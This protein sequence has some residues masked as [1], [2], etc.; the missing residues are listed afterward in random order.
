MSAFYRITSVPLT[1]G[2]L[3]WPF[4]YQYLQFTGGCNPAADLAGLSAAAMS[5]GPVMSAVWI[6][7]KASVVVPLVF[8]CVNG[9]RH[10]GWDQKA[11]GIRHLSQV[12]T[13]GNIVLAVTALLSA[14]IILGP[15]VM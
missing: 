14:M 3:L 2:I 1:M 9:C 12:Y 4:A 10:L 13:S 8:H 5:A 7:L 15:H 11:W 6:S